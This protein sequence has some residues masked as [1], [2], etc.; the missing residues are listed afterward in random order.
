MTTYIEATSIR[1]VG[2]N[3]WETYFAENWDIMGF[4]NGGYMQAIAS[5]ACS[6]AVGG[7]NPVS[8][9]GHFTRPG[10]SG[11]AEV[12][13]E[14]I[15]HGRKF[16][17]VRSRV[18]Q[19][20]EPVLVTLG[21]FSEPDETEPEILLSDA[22]PPDLPPPEQCELAVPASDAPFPP[23]FIGQ[24]ELR[25]GPSMIG[26]FAGRPTG[27]AVVDGWVRPKDDQV[28]DS[29]FLVL[30]SDA[31]PPTAFNAGLPIGWTPTLELTVHIRVPE[32]RGWLRCELKSRF[33][34]GGFIEEDG[35]LWDD[36][37]RLVAQSRQLALVAK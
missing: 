3:R 15:R 24:I 36:D 30:A 29:H 19:D 16:S 32:A 25:V 13:T 35:L 18:V 34:S 31:F 17:V 2:D 23:P 5:R 12:E 37:G 4:T 7:R 21:S 10:H 27:Q 6:E 14:V 8:V 9:T 28:S 11:P 26:T 22:R 1:E 33:V 20:G